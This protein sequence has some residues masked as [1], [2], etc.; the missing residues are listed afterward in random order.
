MRA[1]I[2]AALYLYRSPGRSHVG[3]EQS[4]PVRQLRLFAAVR[5]ENGGQE[6]RPAAL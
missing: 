5:A 6:S 3:L 4:P 1:K 2:R